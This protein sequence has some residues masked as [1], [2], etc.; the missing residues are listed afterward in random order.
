MPIDL[1][2]RLLRYFKTVAEELNFSRAAER[3]HISQPPLSTAIRQ[4]EDSLG[5]TL[6]NRSSR[7]VRLTAAG[8]VLYQEASFLLQRQNEIKSLVHRIGEG[9]IG[10]IRIGFVGSMIYRDLNTVVERCKKQYPGVEQIWLEMNTAEQ[11][12]LIERGGLDIGVIHANPVSEQVQSTPLTNEPFMICVPADH[13]LQHQQHATLQELKDEQFI[14]FSRALSPRYYELLLSMYAQA[15]FYPS[16]R[17]EARHWLSVISLVSQRL[18]VAIVPQCM[19][20][21]GIS[22][23]HFLS[24]EH[25]MRSQN[26]LIWSAQKTSALVKNHVRVLK[27]HYSQWAADDSSQLAPSTHGQKTKKQ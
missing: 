17:F 18:G 1:D 19:S 3:L 7:Q 8:R 14:V 25:D 2:A 4:L 12:A 11:M 24:F 20:Q 5:V 16:I 15:G 13:P 23:V 10:Q 9:L 21:A 26:S 22:G 6:F 27:D